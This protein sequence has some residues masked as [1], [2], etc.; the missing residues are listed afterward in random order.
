[1]RELLIE[2]NTFP[3]L[4]QFFIFPAID[5]TP[6]QRSDRRCAAIRNDLSI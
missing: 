4:E 3:Q 1:M 5:K 6:P 2:M